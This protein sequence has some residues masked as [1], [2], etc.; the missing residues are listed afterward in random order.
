[1]LKK[2]HDS[3]QGVSKTKE[4]AKQHVYWPGIMSDITNLVLTCPVCNKY[5]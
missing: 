4:L 1:M 5:N 2:L 3:H